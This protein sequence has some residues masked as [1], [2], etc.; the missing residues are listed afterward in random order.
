[1][2]DDWRAGS[3]RFDQATVGLTATKLCNGDAL[4]AALVISAPAANAVTLWG[5][6]DVVAGTGII[7]YPG[8]A[9]LKL[10]REEYG[11][12]VTRDLWAITTVAPQVV[13]FYESYA[14][15]P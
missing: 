8:T 5:T 1:M 6:S 9:P 10:C 2:P 13:G 14:K 7:L 15:K 4:R 3:G 12:L 11:D